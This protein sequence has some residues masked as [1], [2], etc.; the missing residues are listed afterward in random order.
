[1]RLSLLLCMPDVCTLI[2]MSKT[3][4]Y[5]TLVI[6]TLK[7]II[8]LGVAHGSVFIIS[9]QL[10]GKGPFALAKDL[11]PVFTQN[12]DEPGFRHDCARPHS[13]APFIPL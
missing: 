1:M 2:T 13:A 3:D 9:C 12:W 10:R 4:F 11:H 7:T 5:S 8:A 6:A